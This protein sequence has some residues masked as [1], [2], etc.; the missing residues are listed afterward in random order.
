VLPPYRTPVGGAQARSRF[1]GAVASGAV[2]RP[3]LS[4]ADADARTKLHGTN[5]RALPARSTGT[6]A[7]PRRK[8]EERAHAV[9]AARQVSVYSS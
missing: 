6:R 8:R 4:A 1:F 7:R 3:G 5:L 2:R 9:A